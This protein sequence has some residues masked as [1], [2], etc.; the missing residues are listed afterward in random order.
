[1]VA[2]HAK[3]VAECDDIQVNPAARPR[4]VP[5][6]I[7]RLTAVSEAY[8]HQHALTLNVLSLDRAE[9]SCTYSTAAWLRMPSL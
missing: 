2:F 1:M 7:C 9:M 3:Y 6:F 5:S 4:Q 8:A